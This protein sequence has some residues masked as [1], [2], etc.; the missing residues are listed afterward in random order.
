MSGL[1]SLAVYA[2]LNVLRGT[3]Y[4]VDESQSRLPQRMLE[5]KETLAFHWYAGVGGSY[6]VTAEC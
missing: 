5:T 3:F 1:Y 4:L 6:R 2:C